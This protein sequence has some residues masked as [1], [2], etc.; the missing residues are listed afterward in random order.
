MLVI[1]EM[2]NNHGGDVA[3]G[4][5]IID[6]FAKVM[7]EFPEFQFA[8][9]FQYRDLPTFIHPDADP[10]DKYVRRFKETNLSRDD[11]RWLKRHAEERGFLTACTPFDEASV[12]HV[13]EDGYD[14][15]KVGSPSITD[16]SLWDSIRDYWN[17]PIIASVGGAT[18]VDV[19]EFLRNHLSRGKFF[20][21]NRLT[22]L[23]CVSEY[24]TK[25]ENLQF[26]QIMYLKEKFPN[27][28]VGLSLHRRPVSYDWQDYAVALGAEVIERH[29][30]VGNPPNKYSAGPKDMESELYA[31]RS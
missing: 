23:H 2:A 20:A 30:F 7:K 21:Y 1:F 25:T 26:G 9:K 11:R 24:P 19:D 12:R 31:L 14:I 13:V 27:H 18:D 4:I 17:G 3:H 29:V 8:F 22:L 10:E 15:L 16:W 6:E 28:K 5:R